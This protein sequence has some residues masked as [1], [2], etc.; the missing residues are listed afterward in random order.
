V[1][2]ECAALIDTASN[3]ALLRTLGIDVAAVET[4]TLP[5]RGV[6]IAP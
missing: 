5:G 2:R 3:A 6:T 4:E 1:E